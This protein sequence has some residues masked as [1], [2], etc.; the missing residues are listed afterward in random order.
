MPV[1]LFR[2]FEELSGIKTLEGY[3]LTEGAC[4]SSVNPP[5]GE[6]RV[7]SIGLRLAHQKMLAAHLDNAGNFIAVAKDDVPGTILIHG[8]NIFAGYLESFHNQD[9]WVEI[10]GER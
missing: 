3:G 6:R 4:V 9:L 7:G 5:A 10:N 8:P 1:E 2:Q